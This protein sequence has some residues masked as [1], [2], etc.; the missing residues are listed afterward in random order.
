MPIS[1]QAAR[2]VRGTGRLLP[3]GGREKLTV[4]EMLMES[5]NTLPLVRRRE[6]IL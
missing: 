5:G 3:Y 4:K 6:E 1:V 2:N